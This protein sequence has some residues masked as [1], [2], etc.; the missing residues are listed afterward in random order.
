MLGVLGRGGFFYPPTVKTI[1]TRVN[2]SYNLAQLT[3][4]LKTAK[5]YGLYLY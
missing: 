3:Q 4:N 5:L 2:P 1:V